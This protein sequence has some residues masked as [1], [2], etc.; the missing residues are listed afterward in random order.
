MLNNLIESRSHTRELKRRGYFFL[1]TVA[2][3]TLLFTAGGIASIYAYEANL[4]EQETEVTLTMVPLEPVQPA[5]PINPTRPNTPN[6]GNNRPSS[7]PT[8]PVIYESASNPHTT[9]PAVST[10]PQPYLPTVGHFVTGNRFNPLGSSGP[11]NSD[12]SGAGGPEGRTAVEIE[13]PPP[14][15]VKPIPNPPKII[16]SPRILNSQA[17]ELP[18]PA[19]PIVAKQIRLSGSVSV[20]VL[21]DEAG[22][23]I[24]A[25]AVSGN[26]LFTRAA[27]ESALR[28]RFSPTMIGETP[29]KVSGV[30]VYNFVLN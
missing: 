19:Y 17:L 3:Y 30:I 14:A 21:I 26:E 16:R 15:P 9:P 11:G 13:T 18:K 12:V 1:F 27:V 8:A 5:R 23:V 22:K 25:H 2:A 7:P 20:Q 10:A 29:V 24:S 28:A 6:A 4:D